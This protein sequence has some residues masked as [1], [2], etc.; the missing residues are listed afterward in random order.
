MWRHLVGC[1]QRLTQSFILRM[2]SDAPRSSSVYLTHPKPRPIGSVM[3]VLVGTRLLFYPD[4]VGIVVARIDAG[5]PA[6]GACAVVVVARCAHEL[7]NM[8]CNCV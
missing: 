7:H 8:P 5:L 4:L 6:Y 3:C 2:L 1:V